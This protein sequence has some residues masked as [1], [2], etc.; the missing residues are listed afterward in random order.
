MH[1]IEMIMETMAA[2]K[3]MSG[4]INISGK[5]YPFSASKIVAGV[6]RIDIETEE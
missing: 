3:R 5:D 1:T 4:E 6:V 2:V